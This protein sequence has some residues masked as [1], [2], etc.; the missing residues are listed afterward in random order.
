[1]TDNQIGTYYLADNPELYEVQ[2]DN[3]FE[4][5]VE[6]LDR[7]LRAGATGDDDS[8][9]ITNGQEVLR[10]STVSTFIPT[11]ELGTIEIKRGNNTMKAAGVPTFQ[12]GQFA[13]NDYI[14]ADSKSVLFA[15]QALAYNV[16]TEKVGRMSAYKKDCTLL[17][18]TPD[19]KLVRAWKL[20]GCWVSNV[21]QTDYN[22]ENSGKKTVTA[23]IQYDKAYIDY[24][25]A[26]N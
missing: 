12:A 22:M 14:G 4:F 17:E 24:D 3:N 21:N 18:Y 8:D 26:T 19:Y 10:F 16:K 11:F 15:W 7:L 25:F 1:M 9:Y 6:G 23:T 2:R 13:I 5:V 20:K